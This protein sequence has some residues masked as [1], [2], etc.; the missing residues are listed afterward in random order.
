M[1]VSDDLVTLVEANESGTL[2]VCDRFESMAL[3]GVEVMMV[4][5]VVVVVVAVAMGLAVVGMR[6]C[7]SSTGVVDGAC[8]VVKSRTS[9]A[10]NRGVIVV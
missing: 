7:S 9:N 5:E 10:N 2:S 3:G 4:V 8:S 1:E 6:V